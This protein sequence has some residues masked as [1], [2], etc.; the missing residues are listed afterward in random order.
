LRKEIENE[1]QF[2]T[3]DAKYLRRFRPS[4]V[5]FEVCGTYQWIKLT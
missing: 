5:H 4:R 1:A 3:A 2:V